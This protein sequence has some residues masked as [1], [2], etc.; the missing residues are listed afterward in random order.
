MAGIHTQDGTL[1]DSLQVSCT[2]MMTLP[3][4]CCMTHGQLCSVNIRLEAS[5]RA[6]AAGC[7]P[8]PCN[9]A[10]AAWHQPPPA[11]APCARSRS[12]G[13]AP[14]P[15]PAPGGSQP[16]AHWARTW[17]AGPPRPCL[18]ARTPRTGCPGPCR[19]CPCR[20]CPPALPLGPCTPGPGCSSPG[21][22][23]SYLKN[24]AVSS[25]A[26]GF[27]GSISK[28]HGELREGLPGQEGWQDGAV[29]AWRWGG[30]GAHKE[31]APHLWS[32]QGGGPPPSSCMN[33]LYA[34]SMG[35]C[36]TWGCTAAAS[37]SYWRLT[38]SCRF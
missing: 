35:S 27:W 15:G 13:A 38:A 33:S 25:R 23:S 29:T 21:S 10:G 4:A 17:R 3:M 37:R 7:M 11:H 31:G 34:L 28:R 2:L 22:L 9:R 24:T 8:S 1:K 5:C 12:R 26:G 16:P 30:R 32:A 19:P 6:Q 14:T 20:C 18:Q 36:C